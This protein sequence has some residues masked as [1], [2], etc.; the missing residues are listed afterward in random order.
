MAT[1][2]IICA[3]IGILAML[4]YM[5]KEFTSDSKISHR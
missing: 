3:S 5:V 4:I 1:A 2:V